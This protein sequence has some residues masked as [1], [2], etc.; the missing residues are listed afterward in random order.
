MSTAATAPQAAGRGW[1]RG[2]TGAQS[3]SVSCAAPGSARHS[4]ASKY[5]HWSR[6]RNFRVMAWGEQPVGR[7]PAGCSPLSCCRTP[8][9]RR[10]ASALSWPP[11]ATGQPRPAD[12][13]PLTFSTSWAA[14][15]PTTAATGHRSPALTLAKARTMSSS[16]GPCCAPRL[17]ASSSTRS[18]SAC[19]QR[20]GGSPWQGAGLG[21]SGTGTYGCPG[22]RQAALL[23][24]E[25]VEGL[26]GGVQAAAAWQILGTCHLDFGLLQCLAQGLLPA[27][28]QGLGECFPGVRHGTAVPQPG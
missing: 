3:V 14:S 16:R 27:Q 6:G 18:A 17:R 5:N 25:R 2:L 24:A 21:R 19:G 11:N 12:P 1:T 26:E 13:A 22:P 23:P 9:P 10:A 15:A 4:R 8:V 20:G 7:Q 28:H